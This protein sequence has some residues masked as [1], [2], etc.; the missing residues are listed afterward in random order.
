MT[1]VIRRALLT[2]AEELAQIHVETWRETYPGLLS[3][4]LLD[5]MNADREATSWRRALIRQAD[6]FD[7]ATF[8]ALKRKTHVGFAWCGPAR[9][10]GAEVPTLEVMMLYVLSAH[11]RRG[12]GRA[13]MGVLADFAISRGMFSMLLWVVEGNAEA[14]QFYKAL[15]GIEEGRRQFAMSA[16]P[17][18]DAIGVRFDDLRALSARLAAGG[19][20]A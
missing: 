2:E 16:G 3:Q 17:A 4:H 8:V 6:S 14:R 13:L 1:Y 7:E 11:Q 5:G 19:A 20:R 15:G 10:D 9:D 18:A 12:L